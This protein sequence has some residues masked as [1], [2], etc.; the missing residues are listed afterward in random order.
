MHLVYMLSKEKLKKTGNGY[1]PDLSIMDK[2]GT[3][4]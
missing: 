4:F 1:F 3:A 2:M